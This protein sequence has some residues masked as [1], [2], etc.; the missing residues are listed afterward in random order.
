MMNNDVLRSVRYMLNLHNEQLLGIL[1]LAEC[2]ITPQQMAGFVKKEEEEGYAPCPDMVMGCFL[3][4]LVI[5][6][7]GRDETM[8][9]AKIE[10]KITNNI[11][12]KKLRVAFS[13]K[14][15]DLQDILQSQDFRLSLPEVT[16]MLR[17]PGHKNYRV[18]GDQV[19]RYFLKGLAARLR[20]AV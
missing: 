9:E 18:C 14:T 8:P 4:G 12:L 17:S 15:N 13:L 16:A 10:R 5:H 20:K 3:H 7:R 2:V 19:L 6:K 11:I 1:A